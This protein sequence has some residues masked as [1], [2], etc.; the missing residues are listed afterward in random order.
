MDFQIL[1]IHMIYC[2]VL[3]LIKKFRVKSFLLC[4]CCC[5]SICRAGNQKGSPVL[6]PCLAFL[7]VAPGMTAWVHGSVITQTPLLLLPVALMHHSCAP[8][9]STALFLILNL[10][11]GHVFFWAKKRGKEKGRGK[12]FKPLSPPLAARAASAV[13]SP[14]SCRHLLRPFQHPL[15]L[16]CSP[17]SVCGNLSQTHHPL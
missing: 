16:S 7:W 1:T 8:Y 9:I 17:A 3:R 13:S 11:W 12:P 14:D 2:R 10:F 15:L 5:C 6:T 4:D